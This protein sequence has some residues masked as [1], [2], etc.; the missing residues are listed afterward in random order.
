MTQQDK[1]NLADLIV[2][3]LEG[4]QTQRVDITVMVG[5]L[6]KDSIRVGF[7]PLP[8]GSPVFEFQDRY[9]VY[10]ETLSGQGAEL[11]FH[12]IDDPWFNQRGEPLVRDWIEFLK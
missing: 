2:G 7:K 4:L 1:L 10:Y 11:R 3:Y 5:V 9:I 8:V 6:K 12:K